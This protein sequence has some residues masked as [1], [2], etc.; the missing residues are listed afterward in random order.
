MPQNVAKIKLTY[1]DIE[2]VA[3]QC[4]LAFLLAGI[5]FQDERIKFQEWKDLKP[6]TPYGK[7]PLLQIG[8]DIKP[9]TQSQAILRYA[10]SL[11]STN[12]LYPLDKAF[13]IEECMGL[14]QDLQTSWTPNLYISMAP[15]AYGHPE[16]FSKTE[17]GKEL[18]EKMRQTWIEQQLPGFLKYLETKLETNGGQ[19]L[20][21]TDQPTIADCYLVPILRNFTK[22]HIDYVDTEC[23]QK[24]S[25][26][27]VEYVQRFCALPAIQGRYTSGLGSE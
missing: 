12:N 27:L 5:P 17:Q 20:C 16:G 8:D 13:E 2:G 24:N 21:G 7:L 6:K 25:P 26:K 4:R 1:F 23:I 14:I 3:E 18:V 10:A 9:K 22:G 19:F 15:Q 11:D